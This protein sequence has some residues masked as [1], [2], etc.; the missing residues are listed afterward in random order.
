MGE[1]RYQ[2]PIC[3]RYFGSEDA[4][5][6]HARIEHDEEAVETSSNFEL[7]LGEKLKSFLNL[8]FGAG[9][10]LGLILSGTAFAGYSY[11][12]S[13]DHRMEVP[14]TV[15]TC[16]NCSYEG[17]RTATDRMFNAEYREVNYQSEE[18]QQLIN[19]YD[20]NYIPAFIFD[21]KVEEAEQFFKVEPVL[22]EYDDAFVVPDR[23]NLVAQRVS[24][25]KELE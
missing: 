24:E 23:G 15:V 12:D 8:S 6:K 22:V 2:C 17:F 16:D 5:R 10:L 11:W 1:E 13:L 4:F 21:R 25:G 20:I 9:L 18:G 14:I 19:K 3:D 7:E